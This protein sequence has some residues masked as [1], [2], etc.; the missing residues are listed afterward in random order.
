[1]QKCLATFSILFNSGN[2]CSICEAK[3]WLGERGDKRT[4]KNRPSTWQGGEDYLAVSKLYLA[5]EEIVR[6]FNDD[7]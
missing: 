2:P 6:L 7:Q 3:S 4:I 5:E 1:M